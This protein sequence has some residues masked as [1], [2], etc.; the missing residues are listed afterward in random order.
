MKT[1]N[2]ILKEEEEKEVTK[3]KI[4]A[5]FALIIEI[6]AVALLVGLAFS[7]PI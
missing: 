4:K 6:L 2:D 5:H 3:Q 1:T 7:N